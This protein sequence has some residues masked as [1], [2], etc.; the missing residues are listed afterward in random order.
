[1]SDS[2][3][4]GAHRREGGR[5]THAA[6]VFVQFAFASQS[7]EAKI[8]MAPSAVG[9]EGVS[10]WALAMLRMAG[11]AIFFQVY[12]RLTGALRPTT[13]RDRGWLAGLS[14]LGIVMNQGLFLLGLTRTTPVTAALLSVTIPVFAAVISVGAG[15][16]RGSPRLVAGLA[17]S[18]AGVVS[19][20]G[21]QRVDLGAVIVVGNCLSYACYVVFSRETIQRLGAP[22]VITWVF[23]WG[24]LLFAP[25][26]ASD[27]VAGAPSWTPRAWT[28]LV[29][30]VIVP[31][32]LAYLANAWA[33]GRSTAT[34][35]TVYAYTQPV[36]TALL[37]WAQMG[38]RVTAKLAW[39]SVLIVLGVSVVASRAPGPPAAP[40]QE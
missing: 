1:V 33:L 7:V 28:F 19:L 35:V 11:A 26:G 37:A 24:A 34:L 10:P 3:S 2:P 27:L 6:L 21:A 30:I 36:L 17:L 13:W 15:K 16:E 8:V 40:I 14:M 23:T 4:V 5:W 32:I 25:L 39:A 12:M 38:E 31:T 9:G 18:I 29:Y 22:T 20:T